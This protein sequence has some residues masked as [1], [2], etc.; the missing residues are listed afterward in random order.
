M[1][2]VDDRVVATKGVELGEMVVIGLSA[3]GGYVHV[4]TVEGAIMTLTYPAKDLKKA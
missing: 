3:G 1:F 4:T 2:S